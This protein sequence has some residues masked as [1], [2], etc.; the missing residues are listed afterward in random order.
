M[1]FIPAAIGAV[2]LVSALS[3][4]KQTFLGAECYYFGELSYKTHCYSPMVFYGLVAAGLAFLAW[5]GYLLLLK[6]QTERA[7]LRHAGYA[8]DASPSQR[9]VAQP[10]QTPAV[11]P[12]VASV[13]ASPAWKTLREF[14]ADIQA[15][16]ARLEPFGVKAEERLA[17]AYL[18]VS[19]KGLLPS[20][21]AKIAADEEAKA[22]VREE[23]KTWHGQ[24]LS[25]RQKEMLAER[26]KNAEQTIRLIKSNGMLYHGRKVES[27]EMYYGPTL[28]EKGWAKV[29]Y[30]DGRVEL[31]AGMSFRLLSD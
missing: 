1:L 15:A 27:A 18:A 19:D 16:V 25:E 24:E 10:V 2:L 3:M 17:T 20:I 26:E 9:V 12:V 31:R 14:D 8:S 21:V 11:Q 4:G 28:A 30:E 6:S 5:T 23:E 7:P 13:V 22:S 29:I